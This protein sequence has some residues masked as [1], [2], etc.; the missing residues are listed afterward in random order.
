MQNT[1]KSQ[2]AYRWD[3]F[4]ALAL[5]AVAAIFVF[6]EFYNIFCYYDVPHEMRDGSNIKL[7]ELFANGVNPYTE[8]SFRNPGTSLLYMYPFLNG[9]AAGGLSFLTGIPAAL[10]IYLLN[11][12]YTVASS[13]IGGRLVWKHT[14]SLSMAVFGF[15]LT[16]SLFWRYGFCCAMPDPMALLE[17]FLIFWCVDSKACRGRVWWLSLLTVMTFYTKQY[18]VVVAA[19]LLLYYWISD[20]KLCLRYFVICAVT[21]I[22]SVAAVYVLMPLYLTEAILFIQQA[23][24]SNFLYC[25]KQYKDMVWFYLPLFAVWGLFVL[26]QL[27]WGKKQGKKPVRAFL[28]A[29]RPFW[30][31]LLFLAV[32]GL[33]LFYFGVSEGAYLTYYLQLFMPAF[34]VVGCAALYRL[35]AGDKPAEGSEASDGLSARSRALLVT[36]VVAL[37]LGQLWLHMDPGFFTK[38]EG[39]VWEEAVE[40]VYGRREAGSPTAQEGLGDAET[41]PDTE[42]VYVSFPFSLLPIMQG[43]TTVAYGQENCLR[44]SALESWQDSAL[45]QKLLPGCDMM[46]EVYRQRE[47]EA[48]RKVEEGGYGYLLLLEGEWEKEALEQ[49]YELLQEKAMPMG[50]QN[51]VMQIWVRKGSAV[52]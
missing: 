40:L 28:K 41:A 7:A 46:F 37:T 14:G 12:I 16:H 15:L 13:F 49:K 27:F 39:K 20:R 34:V 43:D 31:Y 8:A 3:K 6:L 47:A 48:F 32:G 5:A 17:L 35:A 10:S 11:G 52:D 21:T 30:F 4:L 29:E 44:D 45:L 23:A 2:K 38:E 25:L 50:T 33:C 42:A 1:A 22:A 24:N 36:A 51:P 18:F 19:S 9:L 26:R